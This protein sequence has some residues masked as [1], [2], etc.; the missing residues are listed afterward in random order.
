VYKSHAI[1]A[2]GGVRLAPREMHGDE[3]LEVLWGPPVAASRTGAGTSPT[4]DAA[5]RP[6]LLGASIEHRSR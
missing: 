5:S 2:A 3:H 4:I 1:A 6:V